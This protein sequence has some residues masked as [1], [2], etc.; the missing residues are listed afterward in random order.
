[1]ARVFL[2]HR[3]QGLGHIVG[4]LQATCTFLHSPCYCPGLLYSLYVG[5][6]RQTS[7][8]KMSYQCLENK[9]LSM[10][11]GSEDGWVFAQ[12]IRESE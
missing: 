6:R 9:Y 3:L 1:M 5:H 10:S 2:V 12:A 7:G 8:K 4:F 11:K